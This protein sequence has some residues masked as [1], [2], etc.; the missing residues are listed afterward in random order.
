MMFGGGVVAFIGLILLC[1]GKGQQE[2]TE[3]SGQN[4]SQ[5]I[6]LTNDENENS[7]NDEY[8][9][10]ALSKSDD[11]LKEIIRQKED[12]NPQLVNSA[13][14]VLIARMTGTEIIVNKQ[15]T[16]NMNGQ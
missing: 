11:E 8:L 1:V 3:T 2:D 12:Y 4:S 5:T 6:D 10:K 7:I 16:D 13:E 9:G 14:K 15:N